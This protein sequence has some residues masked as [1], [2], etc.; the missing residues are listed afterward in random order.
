MSFSILVGA[1]SVVSVDMKSEVIRVDEVAGLLC[2]PVLSRHR[3][4]FVVG[5]PCLLQEHVERVHAEHEHAAFTR[6]T[7][8]DDFVA[9]LDLH[10]LTGICRDDDLSLRPYRC[11][12]EESCLSAIRTYLPFIL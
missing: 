6:A 2:W 10:R 8:D 7:K 1:Q 4:A 9:F 12:A 11:R 3:G 5:D